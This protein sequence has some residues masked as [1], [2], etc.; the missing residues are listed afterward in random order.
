VVRKLARHGFAS[1]RSITPARLGL[2]Q[3][4]MAYKQAFHA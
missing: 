3:E 1:K 2:F 4:T